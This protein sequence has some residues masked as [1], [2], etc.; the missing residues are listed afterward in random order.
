M[1][2]RIWHGYTSKENAETYE[3]L[4]KQ[5]IFEGIASKGIGG[6]KGIQLLKRQIE[7]EFEFT[8]IMWFES[9]RSVQEFMGE[10]Y[11]TAYVL[12]QAQKLLLKY[13]KKSTHCELRHE[14]QYE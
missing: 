7:D 1:I 4:L 14:L 2:A 3:N 9:I 12:P 10:D 5:E 8:T 11:D 13:D 6:Y